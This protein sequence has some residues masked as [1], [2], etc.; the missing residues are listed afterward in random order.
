MKTRFFLGFLCCCVPLFISPQLFSQ[1]ERDPHFI[2]PTVDDDSKYTTV[3]SIGMTVSNFG[4]FG[5]GFGVQ[6]PVDQPSCEYPKGSGIEHLFVGGLWVGGKRDDGTVFV[7]SGARDIS[8]LRDVAA[9]FEFTNSDDPNDRVAERSSII[10]SPFYSPQAI[11]HQDFI[12]DF[13]DSNIVVPGTTIRIPQHEPINVSV[14]LE[15]YAWNFPFADAF[16]ILNYTIKNTGARRLNQVYVSLWADLVIRNIN[17]TPPRV[18]SPFYQ[19]RS[20]DYVDS[21]RMA[22]AYDYDGDPGFTDNGLYVALKHLGATPQANDQAYRVASSFNSWLFRDTSD[23]VLFSPQTDIESYQKQAEPMD[24]FLIDRVI[25]GRVG[26]FM[27]LLTTG[28]FQSLD[29]DSSINVVFAVICAGK[30]GSDDNRLD[31]EQS[32]QNL[33]TNAFWAQTAYDGE[34]RNANN[35]LDPGEDV[36]R[37]GRLDRYV[38]PTPPSP[39]RVKVIPT[40][41]Q[42]TIYWDRSAEESVDFISGK[43][44]FEGYRLYRTQLGEDLPGHDLFSSFTLIAEFDSVNGI[45]YDT[46][47]KFVR[48]AQPV[49]FGETA[50]NPNTG[51]TETIYYHYKFVNE[52]LLNGWQYAFAVTAFDGGD[53]EIRLASLESSRLSNVVR[54]FPGSPTPEEQRANGGVTE[55]SVGVYPN[56]YRVKA[57]WDGNLERDRK[58]YFYNLPARSQVSIYTLAGDLVDS[59]EHQATN[60]TGDDLQ[61]FEKFSRGD[62]VFAGGEHAWD[63]VTR[64]DQALASGLYYYVVKNLANGNVQRGK[65]LVIK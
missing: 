34:D 61:W 31:T 9:G 47:F 37:D 20:G 24:R 56:P 8:S 1:H 28:P 18:G 35:Q 2:K 17:I 3:G 10:D 12:A 45:G 23:P 49:T 58:I 6:A 43:K 40:D 38:L 22:Y 26:N 48:L 50:L 13:T 46:D 42:V 14:H 60:Y 64:D 52:N 19:H 36:D 4:T 41:R 27:T 62:R 57:A 54:V 16:V 15:S 33:Y 55:A 39:P 65:F 51:Q 30:F 44:D 63:L 5:D 11:S 32:R 59:F 25:K 29:P 53:P 7:T 21:L